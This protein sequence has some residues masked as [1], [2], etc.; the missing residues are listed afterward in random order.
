MIA[1]T[2]ANMASDKDAL[3]A[4]F[5]LSESDLI[6]AGGE[7]RVYAMG[8]DR[9]LRIRNR[10]GDTAYLKRLQRFLAGIAGTLPFATPSIA[11]VAPDGAWTIEPRLPGQPMSALLRRIGGTD[12]RTA[13]AN[14]VAGLDAIGTI[15][16]PD[17]PFGHLLAPSPVVSDNWR[18]FARATLSRFADANRDTVARE[19][20]D[21]EALLARAGAMIADLPERPDRV[22]VHGDCFPGNVLLDDRLE[23]SAVID[24][25]V[26]TLA[27]DALLD[28]AVACLTLETME[29]CGAED[30]AFVRGLIARRH[31]GRFEATM[32]FCRAWLALSMA[33]PANAAPPYPRL[34]DWSLAQLRLLA[35]DR[36]PA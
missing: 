24:F 13:F 8:P 21:P 29:E 6:G 4:R 17:K 9:V 30:V 35:A 19:I 36:L 3:L 20:G 27:G 18:G 16:L 33:D 34:Y 15:A 2:A 5:G 26:F 11:T 1:N 10:A 7:S 25:G 28:G 14:F 23:V 32:R 12:R 22:L 31:G